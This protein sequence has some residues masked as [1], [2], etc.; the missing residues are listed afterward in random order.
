MTFRCFRKPSY[1]AKLVCIRSH[2]LCQRQGIISE[3]YRKGLFQ[4]FPKY[5]TTAIYGG[6]IVKN[7]AHPAAAKAWLAFVQSPT[8]LRIFEHYGFKPYTKS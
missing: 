2:P 4:S 3:A 1:S 8:A 7:A 5:N 6:A